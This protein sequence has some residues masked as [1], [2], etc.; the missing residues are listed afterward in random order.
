MSNK[1]IVMILMT[2]VASFGG[3]WL[4]PFIALLGYYLYAVMRPQSIWK[5]ELPPDVQW[6][7]IVAVSA[8]TATVI[9]RLGL[10]YYPTYGPTA[11]ARRPS[12]FF[13][14]PR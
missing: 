6:S 13:S 8:M 3:L 2:G 5:Y 7:F 10:M 4:G 14:R 11:G 12:G 1:L 9:A